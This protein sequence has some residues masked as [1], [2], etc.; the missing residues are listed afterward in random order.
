[1]NTLEIMQHKVDNRELE[2]RVKDLY[3]MVALHPGMTYHFEMGQT[4]AER[5]GYPRLFL[6]MIPEGAVESFAGVGY[7]FDLANIKA[8]DKVLDLGSG[9]G[10]D[11]FYA[12]IMTGQEGEVL[13]ID[14]TPAQLKKSRSL[15]DDFRLQNV[16]FVEGYIE[17]LSVM[18]ES[19]DVVMSNGVIN[20]S[21]RKANVFQEAARVLKPGGRLAISDIVTNI[22]LPESISGNASLWAAC[23]GG[24]LQVDDYIS[25]IELA[26]MRVMDLK[27]NPYAFLS[28]SAQGATREYEI[29]SISILAVKD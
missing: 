20:L 17:E 18:T 11:V 10:M 22:P 12:A 27:K 2:Q 15:R 26:G 6:E 14:M 25:L 4:L 16:H 29:E 9:S 3:R 23:I 13:G 7:H 19:V 8:G 24:A 21:S 1:M 5:L 28:K